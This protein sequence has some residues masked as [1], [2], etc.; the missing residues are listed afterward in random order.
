MPLH[1]ALR[2]DRLVVVGDPGSGKTTFL[3]RVAHTLCQTQLGDEPDA[4]QSGWASRTAPFRSSSAS[5]NWPSIWPA[6]PNQ[7]AAPEGDD[8]PDWLPH[9]LAAAGRS[10]GWS[11]DAA[12]F[13]QLLEAG[14]CTV[15]LDGLDE[16]PDRPIRERIS[17]LIENV[18]R[19]YA[20]CRFVVT[21]RPAAYTGEAVLPDFAHARIDP[22]ADEAVET[23][24]TRWCQA[25]YVESQKAADEHCGELLSAV[26]AKAEIRRM[27]RNP[28][29]LTALAVVHWNERRLPE[30]RAD[31]YNSIILWL[32]RARE[33]R[34]G[35]AT[36]DR[37][38]VL[39][40]ELALAMQDPPPSK[41]EALA[42]ELGKPERQRGPSASLRD[43]PIPPP[44]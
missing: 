7:G 41:P 38:I 3:R 11:L 10:N 37:T 23:F 4:A 20:R 35:R 32:S 36:A 43:T 5:A 8:A 24:L 28:V 21:S 22:L 29:M 25:V 12:F 2:H 14:H 39:L 18:T 9:Y 6:T 26:R 1:Q 19:A 15:L 30:Q 42:R 17:R 44:A 31:L 27:A 13:R 33:Q 34:P 40:Q 16:A